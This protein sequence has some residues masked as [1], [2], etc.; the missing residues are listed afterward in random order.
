MTVGAFLL[1][2]LR[3]STWRE[4]ANLL[5]G[6]V[7]SIVVFV[8]LVTLTSVG[9]SLLITLVGIPILLATAY[10]NRW[11]ADLERYRAGLVLSERVGRHY[12]DASGGGFW[13]RAR[14][15]ASDP[16]TWKDYAWLLL[17]S[18]IGFTFGLIALVLW[19]TALLLVSIPFWWWIP[20]VDSGDS[21]SWTVDSWPLALLV[22]LV[23][24]VMVVLTAWICAALA[25]GQ[26]LLAR[27]LLAPGLAE[28][29]DE[30]ERTRAGA[31]VAQQ[32]ELERIE[33]DLHDGAQARLVALSIDLGLAREKL[34]SEPEAAAELIDS[35]HA[36]AKSA[37]AELRELVRGVHPVILT[38][39]GLD[40]AVSALAA[41]SPV[42]VSLDLHPGPRLSREV[43]AAAYFVIAESLTN[44]AKHATAEQAWVRVARRDGVLEIEVR[45]DGRGGADPSAG[46]GLPGLARRVE[47]LDGSLSVTSPEAHG[48]IVRAE[49]PCAS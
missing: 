44:V 48:T 49:L 1:R 22:A 20:G 23:G 34:E 43:E 41:R 39:R 12:R 6:F 30:L 36:E 7:M 33:R 35:A 29:V 27:T 5:L 3:A 21:G 11:L 28:R 42:P 15:V 40:A 47:A 13:H 2:P 18:V 14:V 17:V 46:T 16:Q 25:R 45:D 8:V 19:A 10:V 4:L 38:D 32:D 26:A 9:L 31:V 24:L 37:L